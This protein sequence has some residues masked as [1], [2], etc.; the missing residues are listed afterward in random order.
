MAEEEEQEE[1]E[2]IDA[3]H[4]KKELQEDLGN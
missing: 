2:L 3:D 4:K 1:Q